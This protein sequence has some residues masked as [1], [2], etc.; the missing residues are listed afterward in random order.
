MRVFSLILAV[1]QV[2]PVSYFSIVFLGLMS[3]PKVLNNKLYVIQRDMVLLTVLFVGLA[4]TIMTFSQMLRYSGYAA[5]INFSLFY[6][7]AIISLVNRNLRIVEI[8]SFIVNTFYVF[9]FFYLGNLILFGNVAI[10]PGGPSFFASLFN[11]EIDRTEI[12]LSGGI[13]HLGVMIG[14]LLALAQPFWSLKGGFFKIAF[15]ILFITLLLFL[16]SRGAVSALIFLAISIFLMRRIKIRFNIFLLIPVVIPIL[17]LGLFE[18]DIVIS[19]ER[20]GSTLFSQR[21]LIWALGIAGFS[22]F[23][24]LDFLFGYG[25]NGFLHNVVSSQI[26]DLFAYR[27]SFGSMHNGYLALFYDRGLLGLIVYYLMIRRIWFVARSNP[28][29]K[30]K[31]YFNFLVYILFIGATETVFAQNFMMVSILLIILSTGYVGGIGEKNVLFGKDK[32]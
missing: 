8:S 29:L 32:G 24:F 14:L 13:N 10:R 4:G 11:L 21:E 5:S 15:C 23:T 27:E 30:G 25:E 22:D 2:Y 9:F 16:D 26:S 31:I 1:V 18:N 28:H 20:Q 12:Y 3:A 6:I 19:L 7:L 17:G